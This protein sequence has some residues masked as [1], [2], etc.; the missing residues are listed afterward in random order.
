MGS[1]MCIRDS[2]D[3]DSETAAPAVESP[4]AEPVPE[5]GEPVAETRPARRPRRAAPAAADEGEVPT[6]L[7]G[8]LTRAPAPA[9]AAAPAGGPEPPVR[10]RAPRRKAEAATTED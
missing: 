7:P 8:F 2:A 4:P 10:R 6:A 5:A 9:A 1:E 3:A